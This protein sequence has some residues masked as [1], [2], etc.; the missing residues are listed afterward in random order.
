MEPIEAARVH[1]V[2]DR[3][4]R[5]KDIAQGF[6]TLTGDRLD[7]VELR[8]WFRRMAQDEKDQRKILVKHLKELCPNPHADARIPVS[9]GHEVLAGITKDMTFEY[10]EILR[11]ATRAAEDARSFADRASD[12][13]GERSCRIFLKILAEEARSHRDELRRI[14]QEEERRLTSEAEAA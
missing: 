6:F 10:V 11:L 5:E 2:L 13:V 9:D 7:D 12:L 14:L 3:L 4:A 1:A 8:R